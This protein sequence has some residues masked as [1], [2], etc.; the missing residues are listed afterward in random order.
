MQYETRIETLA[1]HIAQATFNHIDKKNNVS[2]AATNLLHLAGR[3]REQG[4]EPDG[5]GTVI[6]HLVHES[7]YKRQVSESCQAMAIKKL[8]W[9]TRNR[10]IKLVRHKLMSL[11]SSSNKIIEKLLSPNYLQLQLHY[12]SSLA[13]AIIHG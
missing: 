12:Y 8:Q 11:K 5:P 2:H 6:I 7:E 3:G 1:I 10:I 9:S 4:G 13:L